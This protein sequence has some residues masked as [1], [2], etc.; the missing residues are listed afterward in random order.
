MRRDWT[1]RPEKRVP[2]G[3]DLNVAVGFPLHSTDARVRPLVKVVASVLRAYF[4][5]ALEV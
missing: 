4:S 3:A 2:A 5:R 1:L